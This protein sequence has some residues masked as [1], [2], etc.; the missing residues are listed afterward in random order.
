MSFTFP[1]YS[2][3]MVTDVDIYHVLSTTDAFYISHVL[4][5]NDDFYIYHVLST[6]VNISHLSCTLN[7]WWRCTN[8]YCDLWTNGDFL[9]LLRIYVTLY[10]YHVLS[11][12]DNVLHVPHTLNE[13]WRVCLRPPRTLNGYM[14]IFFYIY[15]VI[16]TNGDFLHMPCPLN[17][18]FYNNHVLFT[19]YLIDNHVLMNIL[20]ID[21]TNTPELLT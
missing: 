6:N 11:T 4:S 1:I 17:E 2:Q 16:S 5:T 19:N 15:N 20:H 9:L 13:P 14:M 10:I 7:N 12:N 18:R 3:Q 8:M 21:I